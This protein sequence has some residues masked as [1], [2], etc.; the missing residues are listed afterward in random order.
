M[1]IS[2]NHLLEIIN[3]ILDISKIE[4]GELELYPDHT[5]LRE[6]AESIKSMMSVK[7]KEK[8][9]YLHVEIDNELPAMVIVD[10]KRFRQ[11]L[12]NLTG[13]AIKF[14]QNGGVMISFTKRESTNPEVTVLRC[15][16]TDTGRGIPKDQIEEICVPFRQ[17]K[18]TYSEGTGL[19][20]AITK[21]IL[22][23][24]G[25]E[26]HIESTEGVGSTFWFD[27]DTTASI[28]P[29]QIHQEV[30][31]QH[32]KLTKGSIPKVLVVDD[33]PENLYIIKIALERSGLLVQTATNGL[34]A[35]NTIDKWKPEVVLMDIMMPVMNGI[36]TVKRIR[37]DEKI[38][39]LPVI[40]VTAD[41]LTHSPETLKELG[42]TSSIGKP[43]KLEELF[44]QLQK[45]TPIQFNS[46]GDIPQE[47]S[48]QSEKLDSISEITKWISSL[49]NNVRATI[50]DAID[51]QDF[52]VVTSIVKTAELCGHSL[53]AET[54]LLQ[55]AENYDYSF[56][57]K[58]SEELSSSQR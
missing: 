14:T 16:V 56:F 50:T 40:A 32:V 38:R 48:I 46:D 15:S 42:F 36:E 24:M 41:V 6:I 3:D 1:N 13:N 7:A 58:L 5:N 45:H 25:S 23:K 51:L 20:L 55:A 44:A 27:L 52:E 47:Y 43:F 8:N 18:R 4:A 11:M 10:S 35:L 2:G 12:I 28:Q 34:E 22:T 33:L 17:Q 37:K 53:K 31:I 39:N 19:G 26:L 30:K 29:V 21:S 49:D 54:L 9:L 57:I